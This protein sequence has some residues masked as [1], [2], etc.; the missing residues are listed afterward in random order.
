[1]SGVDRPLPL[2]NCTY[3]IKI[4]GNPMP[5]MFANTDIRGLTTSI[6]T[7]PSTHTTAAACANTFPVLDR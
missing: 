4:S 1:M 2:R 6:R 7:K 5:S 3:P